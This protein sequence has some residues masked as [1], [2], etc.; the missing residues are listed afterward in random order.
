MLSFEIPSYD[1]LPQGL[2]KS[3]AT[4]DEAMD[5]L[6]QVVSVTVLLVVFLFIF[7]PLLALDWDP[8]Y[9]ML[10]DYYFLATQ[11]DPYWFAGVGVGL[12][13]GLSTYGAGWGI[14]ICGTGIMGACVRSPQV[15]SRNLISV[16]FCEAVGIYGLIM[17]IVL[18]TR[19]SWFQTYQN[20][21]VVS[22]LNPNVVLYN[23]YSLLS[24]GLIVGFGNI[25]CGLSV[26]I[27]GCC[28]VIADAAERSTYVKIL[29]VEIFASAIGI[30]ALIVAI[31]IVT[32]GVH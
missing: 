7:L 27:L 6:V 5:T 31:V 2:E 26:G 22:A 32:A 11:M 8:V 20:G 19:Y 28:C 16:I 30:F 14:H 3:R 9:I 17:A 12:A 24:A 29:V 21:V 13:I 23:G 1:V 15:S 18:S 25:A 10:S 4:V